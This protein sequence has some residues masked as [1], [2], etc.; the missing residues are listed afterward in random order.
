MKQTIPLISSGLTGPLGVLHLP[1][2]WQKVSLE[3]A[4]KLHSDYPAIGGGYDQMVLDG[5]GLD[6]DAFVT[7]MQTKPS[8]AK[9][10]EW[11]LGQKGGALD[12]SAVTQL[13]D[14]I[15]GYHHDDATRKGIL[16]ASG[17]E[18]DGRILDAVSLNNLEDWQD[19]YAQEI[20]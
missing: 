4:S 5:L 9:L 19:F 20:A 8:Y 7:F 17:L 11:V 13:N 15:T 1:R 18:D 2:L 12:A 14:S 3:N 6:K 16:A 10:E